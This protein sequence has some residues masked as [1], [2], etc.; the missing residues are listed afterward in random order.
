MKVFIPVD[1]GVIDMFLERGWGISKNIRD[2]DLIQFTGGADIEAHLYNLPH[3][4]SMYYSEGRTAKELAAYEIAKKLGKPMAG[5]CRG[6]QFL[7]VMAGG[8]MW[9]HVNGHGMSHR[10]SAVRSETTVEVT[11]CHHQCMI[12]T[13]K[14]DVLMVAHE[15]SRMEKM[16]TDGSIDVVTGDKLETMEVLAYWD[17]G[18]FCWQGHPE[19]E[20]KPSLYFSY[21]ERLLKRN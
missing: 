12:P 18:L 5:I 11:S 21:I 19:W 9:Q 1:F 20:R 8:S 7:N 3:H 15:A 10:M 4:K 14:A 16:N 6:A 13:D 17:M 2:A